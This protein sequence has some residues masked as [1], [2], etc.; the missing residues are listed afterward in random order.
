VSGNGFFFKASICG[1]EFCFAF[2]AF[3]RI[4]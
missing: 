3:E 4:V 2:L 1:N